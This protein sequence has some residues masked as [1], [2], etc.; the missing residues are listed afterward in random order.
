MIHVF[1]AFCGLFPEADEAVAAVA[2]HLREHLG[3]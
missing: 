2:A 3:L 1:H